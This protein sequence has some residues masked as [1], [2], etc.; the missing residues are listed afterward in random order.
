MLSSVKWNG[1][2]WTSHRCL[3]HCGSMG[4]NAGADSR[5][6]AAESKRT[7]VRA[8]RKIIKQ[9]VATW[10]LILTQLVIDRIDI[11]VISWLVTDTS[12]ALLIHTLESQ[13]SARRPLSVWLNMIKWP[14]SFYFWFRFN[15]LKNYLFWLLYFRIRLICIDEH[16]QVHLV[17]CSNFIW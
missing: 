11:D 9:Q 4:V 7:P 17:K 10:Y 2:S 16:F 14:H 12:S 8:W 5:I 15:M 6:W 1:E 3:E 13:I